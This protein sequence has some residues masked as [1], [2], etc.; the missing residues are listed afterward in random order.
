MPKLGLC[1][2]L[3][4]AHFD[5]RLSFE[6]PLPT[7]VFCSLIFLLPLPRSQSESMKLQLY[8][9]LPKQRSDSSAG[10]PESAQLY[11]PHGLQ[12]AS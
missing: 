11:T 7:C 10:H 6:F 4:I 5:L 9:S 1:W 12:E 8:A 3:K 2:A